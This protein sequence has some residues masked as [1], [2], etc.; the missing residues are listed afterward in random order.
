MTAAE[1]FKKRLKGGVPHTTKKEKVAF[2]AYEHGS[3]KFMMGP[4]IKRRTG[5]NETN[6][7]M[8]KKGYF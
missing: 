5:R 1:R 7:L 2:N 3:E 6:P 4:K 8:R